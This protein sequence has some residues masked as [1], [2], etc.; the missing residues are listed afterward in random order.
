[1]RYSLSLLR[2]VSREDIKRAGDKRI[3]FWAAILLAS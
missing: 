3:I 1:M 2:K